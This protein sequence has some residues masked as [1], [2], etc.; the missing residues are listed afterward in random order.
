MTSA[1]QFVR[2]V[3]GNDPAKPDELQ[4]H[5]AGTYFTLR[6]GIVVASLL[7][8]VILYVAGNFRP[9]PGL[10][11][12]I[13][14]YYAYGNN[15]TRNWFVG[16]LCTV[17]MFL[18][19]YKGYSVTENVVLNV[20]GVLAIVVALVPCRCGD[21]QAS[22]SVHGFAAVTFFLCIAFVCVRC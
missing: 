7:L 15:L 16:T 2:S 1:R 14:H 10:L 11:P 9:D 5:F 22:A 18:Y 6:L 12:S 8:P 13:S 21:P 3:V 20:A 19:L 4:A 17:G